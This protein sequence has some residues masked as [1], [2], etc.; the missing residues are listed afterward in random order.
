[1]ALLPIPYVAPIRAPEL[2]M[3]VSYVLASVSLKSP[4]HA[5]WDLDPD[6]L[7]ANTYIQYP[8]SPTA[9]SSTVQ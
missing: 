5:R 8:H 7:T 9:P 3:A 1:M 6:T 2:S 4:M